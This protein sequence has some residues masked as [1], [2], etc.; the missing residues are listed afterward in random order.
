MQVTRPLALMDVEKAVVGKR[1]ACKPSQEGARKLESP[2]SFLLLLLV[3][4][5]PVIVAHV[6]RSARTK[7]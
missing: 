2:L 7:R 4:P 1:W 3:N 5:H 6:D